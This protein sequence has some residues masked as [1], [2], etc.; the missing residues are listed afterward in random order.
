MVM[1]NRHDGTNTP[2]W[3]DDLPP[4][5]RNRISSTFRHEW[6]GDARLPATP[7]RDAAACRPSIV[8]DLS[9]LA[10]LFLVVA[11][12]NLFFLLIALSFLVGGEPIAR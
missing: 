1:R 9:R 10:I 11:I 8:L 7:T 5:V 4:A 2:E 3:W 12:A 6:D